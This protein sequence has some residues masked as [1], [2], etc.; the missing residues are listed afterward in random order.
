MD[1]ERIPCTPRTLD[2]YPLEDRILLSGEG[3]ESVDAVSVEGLADALMADSDQSESASIDVADG[4]S[5]P[6]T[7]DPPETVDAS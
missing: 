4:S 3:L 6:T 5:A 2:F 7:T 1:Q